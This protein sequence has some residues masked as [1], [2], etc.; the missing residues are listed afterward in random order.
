M[1][2]DLLRSQVCQ[3]SREILDTHE[4]WKTAMIEKGWA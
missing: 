1:T 3:S 2:S 4:A